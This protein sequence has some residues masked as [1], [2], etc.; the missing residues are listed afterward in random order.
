MAERTVAL[1]DRLLPDDRLWAQRPTQSE[2]LHQ[3]SPEEQRTILY[4]HQIL[5]PLASFI[6]KDFK[7]PVDLNVPG[8]GWYWNFQENRIA[9]DPQDLLQRELDENRFIISHEG[10]HRRISRPAD[11]IPLETWKQPGYSFMFNV[12]EDPRVNSFLVEAYPRSR[13]QMDK[14]YKTNEDFEA[15]A[16]AEGKDRLGQVPRF[17][18]AGFEYI[19]QWFRESQGQEVSLSEGLPDD[20]RQVLQE[21]L[22]GAR[23][24]WLTYP[25]R[26]EANQGEEVIKRYAKASASIMEEKVW[27]KFKELIDKDIEDQKKQQAMNDMNQN[28][29]EGSGSGMPQELRDKLTEEEKQELEQALENAMNETPS[30]S[31]SGQGQP[32]PIDLDSL[33]EGLKQK[34]QDYIDSLPEDVKRDLAERAKQV[35]E[36]Y[37]KE[38]DEYLEGK[39]SDNPEKKA[40]RETTEAVDK[41][42]KKPESDEPPVPTA[43]YDPVAY[44]EQQR[45]FRN[46]AEETIRRNET[47]YEQ[48]RRG[49]LPII[50]ELENDLREVFVQ[51]RA[52]QWQGGFKSGKR[53]DIVKRIQEKAKG[54]PAVESRAWER[55]ELPQEKDYAVTLL[56]DLSGSMQG[57]K[58]DET[59]KAAIVL[60]EV[61]NKLSIRTEIIGFNDRL[62][63]YQNFGQPMSKDVRDKM[64]GMLQEVSDVSDTGKA[65]WND[66]GWALEQVSERLARQ[67]EA[68]EKF[69]IVLSD[70]LPVES[71]LHPREKYELKSI[72]KKIMEETDQ[73]LIGLGLGA[74]T[75]HVS[76]YYPNSVADIG[77]AEM[78]GKL[79]DIIREAIANYDTF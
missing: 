64:G 49:V 73:K 71:P 56:V 53:V 69:L 76:G 22:E 50:D 41:P 55:R 13:L 23:E 1:Q 58:I 9:I 17:V 35:M 59:F 16:K 8:G 48:T 62:Y 52:N 47:L 34:L 61:L 30:E 65:R 67:R 40:E 11:V 32:R 18:Q 46:Q 79:A 60:A 31:E 78:A 33:S 37:Q 72:I 6:G 25:S 38:L 44:E 10:S 45:Q 26:E 3:Y 24:A 42:D 20:V 74:G 15:K 57:E 70:G 63:E 4:R 7:I 2:I 39:L 36:E 29:E 51:R 5:R 27:S 68:T 66:D 77:A 19:K 21:T 14:A 28:G 75:G 54:V 43:I 12:I